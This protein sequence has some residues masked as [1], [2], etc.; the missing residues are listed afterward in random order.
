MK[1]KGQ[2]KR[3]QQLKALK[4]VAHAVCWA[5]WHRTRSCLVGVQ[6]QFEPKKERRTREKHR[7]HASYK[8]EEERII[9]FSD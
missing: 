2:R 6:E 9:S 4:H 5:N 3:E 1:G 8:T 7:H